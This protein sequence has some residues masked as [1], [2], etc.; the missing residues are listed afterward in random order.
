[1]LAPLNSK[2]GLWSNTIII[3]G[4]TQEIAIFLGLSIYFF[5]FFFFYIFSHQK[6]KNESLGRRPK[7]F[8]GASS[9]PASG[10]YILVFYVSLLNRPGVA[11]AVL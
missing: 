6:K 9:K 2:T 1:M 3:N 5:D 4:K 10:L 11:G 7:P 8:A